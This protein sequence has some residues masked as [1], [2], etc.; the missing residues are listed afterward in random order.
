MKLKFSGK[1]A[2]NASELRKEQYLK[3][4]P[5]EKQMEAHAEAAMG[6]PEKLD[7]MLSDFAKIRETIKI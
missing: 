5:I 2:A 3:H 7:N 6:R 1:G 4:W